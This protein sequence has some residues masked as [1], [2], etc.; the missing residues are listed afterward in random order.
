MDFKLETD[1]SM[2]WT[3]INAYDSNN[4]RIGKLAV[5]ITDDHNRYAKWCNGDKIAKIIYVVTNISACGNGIATAMLN[6][7]IEIFPDYNLY[8]N[9]VPMP[10]DGESVNHRTVKG[11]MKFYEKFGFIRCT[12]DICV[13][14]MIRKKV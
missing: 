3:Y 10:R 9:V 12:D 6:K 4:E 2:N 14:T 13:T 8:L 11:L 7:A 1:S 5:E